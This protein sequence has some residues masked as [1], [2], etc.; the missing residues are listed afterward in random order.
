M[1]D[2]FVNYGQTFKKLTLTSC[3]FFLLIIVPLS[4]HTKDLKSV[5]YNKTKC[6]NLTTKNQTYIDASNR[7]IKNKEVGQYLSLLEKSKSKILIMEDFSKTKYL[8]NK[9]YWSI[10]IHE[11]QESHLVFWKVFLVEVGGSDIHE[12]NLN[13]F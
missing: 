9:C 1:N 11:S 4:G 2:N 12:E 3:I 8:D 5:A 13:F 10:S 7:L 6:L